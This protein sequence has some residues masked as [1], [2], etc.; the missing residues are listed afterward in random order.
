[1]EECSCAGHSLRRRVREKEE[2][3]RG[4]PAGTASLSSD[5]LAEGNQFEP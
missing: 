2:R 5:N 4:S 3:E 1:M